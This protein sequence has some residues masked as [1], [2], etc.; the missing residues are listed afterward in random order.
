[1]TIRTVDVRVADSPVEVAV[2]VDRQPIE[3]VVVLNRWA[4]KP[5]PKREPVGRLPGAAPR[6]EIR[7]SGRGAHTAAKGAE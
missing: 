4:S 3:V 6:S 5:V 7:P 2:V 1:M